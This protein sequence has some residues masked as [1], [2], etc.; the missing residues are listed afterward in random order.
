MA[1]RALDLVEFGVYLMNVEGPTQGNSRPVDWADLV[2]GIRAGDEEAVLRLGDIFQGVI[3]FFLRRVLVIR[4]LCGAA[5]VLGWRA[6]GSARADAASTPHS[7][8]A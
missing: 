8:S 7:Q 6:K 2:A 1:G 5:A 4:T 3:R